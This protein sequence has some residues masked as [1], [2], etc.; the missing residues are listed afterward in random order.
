MI[1]VAAEL[2]RS[3][4]GRVI[5]AH[6]SQSFARDF[7]RQQHRTPA[8]VVAVQCEADIIAALEI[9]SRH[10][11]PCRVRGAGHSCGGQTLSEGG[12]VLL[13]AATRREPV[14]VHGDGAVEMSS[15][16]RW[17]WVERSARARERAIP[18]LGDWPRLTVGGTLSVGGYGV[19]S[20]VWGSQVNHV[21]RI[22]L[23]LP[24]GRALWCSATEH[25]ALFRHSLAGLG[26]LGVIER[27]VVRTVP[28]ARWL[29]LRTY[30]ANNLAAVADLARS[31]QQWHGPWPDVFYYT[32]K[33]KRVVVGISA[34]TIA[35]ARR[36][37][38]SPAFE[39]LQPTSHI[40]V[41]NR[42]ALAQIGVAAWLAQFPH[43]QRVWSDFVL[44]ARLV[45]AFLE[46]VSE[47][48][49]GPA[50]SRHLRTIYV[51]GIRTPPQAAALPLAPVG[52]PPAQ[53]AFGIGLYCMVPVRD[54]TGLT[55][56]RDALRRC[57]VR[58]IEL[59]G[60]P[61]M[62]GWHEL[63]ASLMQRAFGDGLECLRAL[64]REHDPQG[65]LHS[66]FDAA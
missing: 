55:A 42:P 65:L 7:G 4:P 38:P 12:I 54:H 2:R 44:P 1:A 8:A 51:L 62:Y 35:A 58:C 64:R 61:Y 17:T 20:L 25:A 21:L 40:V 10:R 15:R 9:A 39:Q 27:A 57:L 52:N 28:R 59:G 37:P 19:G 6:A 3:L 5:A 43:H 24:T 16:C 33:R 60:R 32:G 18:V 46:Y 48:Q 34:H 29:S 23:V 63:D 26:A 53:L 13:N 47:L 22:R 66:V 30:R 45:P 50:F 31:L 11:V 36:T 41:P 49:R 14:S 56:V